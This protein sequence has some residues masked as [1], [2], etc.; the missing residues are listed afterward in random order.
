V[1]GMGILV[2]GIDTDIREGLFARIDK[3]VCDGHVV[4]AGYA[5]AV[6][7]E[8]DEDISLGELIRAAVVSK[9]DAAARVA[10]PAA[11]IRL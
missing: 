4:A 10:R 9:H 6:L 3:I 2:P 7:A 5:D 11:M 8:I 1:A